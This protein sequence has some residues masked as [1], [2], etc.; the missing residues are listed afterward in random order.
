M[1]TIRVFYVTTLFAINVWR[2][3]FYS[4][5]KITFLWVHKASLIPQHLIEMPVPNQKIKWVV[6]WFWFCHYIRLSDWI[7][8]LFRQRG[9]F[10]FSIRFQNCSDSVVFVVFLLDFR[11]VPTAWYF[12]VFHFIKHRRFTFALQYVNCY[13]WLSPLR[14][15]VR[16]RLYQGIFY[17]IVCNKVHHRV[18]V[19]RFV[20]FS[21]HSD[22]SSK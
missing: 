2:F 1:L 21:G 5:M 9:I 14:L 13:R 7:S 10:C 4:H 19:A 22:S 15:W 8:E 11:T 16:F 18:V 17:S 20:V 6:Y 3:P 12:C